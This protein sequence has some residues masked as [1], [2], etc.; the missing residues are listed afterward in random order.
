MLP[1]EIGKR[2]EL[3]HLG[4]SGNWLTDL[5][6]EIVLLTALQSLN[7]RGN[8]LTALPPEIVQLTALRSIDL[9]GNQLTAL[10]PEIERFLEGRRLLPKNEVTLVQL[11]P[12]HIHAATPL[13]KL[14]VPSAA[15]LAAL[16]IL[17]GIALVWLGATGDT[18]ISLFGNSF[19][20]QNVGIASI[21]CGAVLAVT[22]F[23]RVLTSVERL[24][25]LKD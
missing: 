5:P 1:R 20:S 12:R 4:L 15:I 8:Q 6:R 25:R 9:H 10:P 16:F 17:G 24:G 7:L 11:S 14:I 21:F 23:R 3:R 22:T 2:T 13:L 19:K 18:E